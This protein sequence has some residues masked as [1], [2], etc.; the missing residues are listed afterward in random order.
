MLFGNAFMTGTEGTETL[1]KRQ[2]NI[3]ANA[4]F[5]IGLL[6]TAF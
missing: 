1:T 2:V 3:Q 6:E 5:G 4:L